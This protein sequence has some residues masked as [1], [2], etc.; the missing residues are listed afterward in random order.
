M[1]CSNQLGRKEADLRELLQVYENRLQWL[2]KGSRAWFGVVKTS[3]VALVVDCSNEA[4]ADEATAELHGAWLSRL[5]SEQL[6]K[7]SHISLV[8][9]GSTV[10]A[11]R[12]LDLQFDRQE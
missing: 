9:Y 5:L 4:L 10:E 12:P 3:S 2:A 1:Y 8:R 6:A 11:C 7:M